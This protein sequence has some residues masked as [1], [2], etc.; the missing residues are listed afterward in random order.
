MR[1]RLG[2]AFA[3][4]L[5]MLMQASIASSG[6]S[7]ADGVTDRTN[8]VVG[9]ATTLESVSPSSKYA[10]VFEDDGDTGYFYALDT[11]KVDN[12]IVDALQIY[13]VRS[14]IDGQTPSIVEVTWSKSGEQAALLINSYPHAVFDFAGKRGY[15]RSGFPQPAGEWSAHSHE[16]ND[17][18]LDFFR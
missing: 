3:V 8:L 10:V 15:C 13:N 4:L 14:V 1:H 17:S 18:A 12:P 16:W 11:S 9:K 7:M 6:T 5:W 2:I